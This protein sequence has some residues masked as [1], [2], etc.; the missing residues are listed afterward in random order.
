MW[1][2][3]LVR[4]NIFERPTRS[5]LTVVGLAAAIGAVVALVGIA[6][7]FEQSQRAAF[8]ARGVDLIVVR[9]GSI[10]RLGSV[11]DA[12]LEEKVRALPGV[13]AVSPG[14]SD[15]VSF[16]AKQVFGVVVRGVPA[17]SPMM[18]DV[19]VSAGRRIGPG[20]K[21]AVML[22]KVLAENLDQR[23]GDMLEVIEGE[24][25]YQVVGLFRS[26]DVFENG[27]ILM[28]I[29]QLQQLMR[30]EGEVTQFA[31]A[32]QKSDKASI[33]QL[34]RR[35][36]ALAPGLETLPAGEY[37]DTALEV[38]MAHAVAWLTSTLALL[39]GAFGMVNTMF[40]AVVERTR[41][42]ALL[43]AIGW[44]KRT[45]MKLILCESLLLGMAGAVLGTAAAVGLTRLLSSLPA[46]GRLVSG[47]IA[48]EV[49]LQGFA[50]AAVLSV[51][52]GILPAYRAAQLAPTEG[53]RRQ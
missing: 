16:Q 9:S 33:E 23:A 7:N 18:T 20:D 40:A 3:T 13:R 32:A 35:I 52:G 26:A 29:E 14:L 21:R 19:N 48:P 8:E 37:V 22:G 28:K 4:K 41:E 25:P 38:R 45:V 42:L 17:D 51:I 6:R 5:F 47:E 49:I 2:S 10:M 44:R 31:V 39:I 30:R 36:K 34:S 46:S 27:S 43:R 15:V 11:L 53:L 1:F 24:P 12:G 50:I